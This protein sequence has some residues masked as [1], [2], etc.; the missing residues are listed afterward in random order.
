MDPVLT[1]ADVTVTTDHAG[2]AYAV[3]PD[4]V[5]RLLA[6]ASRK[7][8]DP[9]A[10]GISF[11]SDLHPA[12]SWTARTVRTI[13]EAVLASPA[14]TEDHD[15]HGLAQYRKWD[16]GTFYGFIV[17]TSG[18]DTD[19][20]WWRDYAHTRDVRVSGSANIAARDRRSLAGTCTFTT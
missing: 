6:D 12:D 7:G 18:W 9:E 4:D 16:G 2:R 19:T 11:E 15:A 17:G 10:R 14:A 13:F 5:A 8:I 1:P 20:R 3:V